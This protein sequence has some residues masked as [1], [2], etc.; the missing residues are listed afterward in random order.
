VQGLAS[1]STHFRSFWRRWRDCGI[2]C[3]GGMSGN[4]PK[5]AKVSG[6][7][8]ENLS[9]KTGWL[10]FVLWGTGSTVLFWNVSR[11]TNVLLLCVCVFSASSM[12]CIFNLT[13]VVQLRISRWEW[14]I[15]NACRAAAKCP[16]GKVRP[17]LSLCCRSDVW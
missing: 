14:C 8:G 6:E 9:T 1:H 4:L 7:G 5:V 12:F 2:N 3:L 15:Q 17:R 13:T 16:L 10:V 11:E